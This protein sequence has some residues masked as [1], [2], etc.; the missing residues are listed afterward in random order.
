MLTLDLTR[1][2]FLIHICWRKYRRNHEPVKREFV[3]K[4]VKRWRC[5]ILRKVF[6]VQNSFLISH[7][8]WTPKND[9]HFGYTKWWTF[10]VGCLLGKGT[11]EKFSGK[12]SIY[13]QK[14]LKTVHLFSIVVVVV[15]KSCMTL[16]DPMDYSTPGLPMPHYI[17][18]FAQITFIELEI[19][20]N[21]FIPCCP[22]LLLPSIFPSIRVF[23]NE[24]ALDIRCED[25][26]LP[27]LIMDLSASMATQ[28][29]QN[30]YFS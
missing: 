9:K 25:K 6:Q 26:I 20:S 22:L 16:C 13:Y 8:Y 7:V 27:Y 4:D 12:F 19:L 11:F 1:N 17:P 21:H 30:D 5:S 28:Y 15:S 14:G 18:E 23:S 10:F 29:T 3:H 24:S 2:R